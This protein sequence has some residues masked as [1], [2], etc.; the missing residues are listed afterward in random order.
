MLTFDKWRIKADE[1]EVFWFIHLYFLQLCF[2]TCI[3][4]KWR[5]WTANYRYV[6]C[7]CVT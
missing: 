7:M 5:I 1:W 4:I 2:D 6:L 3:I